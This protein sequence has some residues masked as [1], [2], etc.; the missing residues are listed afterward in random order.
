MNLSFKAILMSLLVLGFALGLVGCEKEG[1][2]ER[3]GQT[4]DQTVEKT[5]DKVEDV[6]DSA[7]R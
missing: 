4:V 5:G 1:P 3:A 2:A 7:T 6:T